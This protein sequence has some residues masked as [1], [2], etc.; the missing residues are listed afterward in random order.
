MWDRQITDLRDKAMEARIE[1]L[2]SEA[3]RYNELIKCAEFYDCE[4]DL[5]ERVRSAH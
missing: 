3:L 1:A 5:M 4:A 2:R